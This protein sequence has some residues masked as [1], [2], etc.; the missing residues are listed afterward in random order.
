MVTLV[1]EQTKRSWL[2]YDFLN[3]AN[4]NGAIKNSHTHFHIIWP[5][6]TRSEKIFVADLCMKESMGSDA[7]FWY[8]SI[9][10]GDSRFRQ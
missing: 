8:E 2:R 7:C 3:S 4:I 10:R 9:T 1:R 5:G 6:N